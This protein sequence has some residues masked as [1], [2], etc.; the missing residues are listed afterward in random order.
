MEH[1]KVP[2][3][4]KNNKKDES[5]NISLKERV[6]SINK[7]S[8]ESKKVKEGEYPV[9]HCSQE[10]FEAPKMTE[11]SAKKLI[12]FH[13]ADG[14]N[15]YGF[16]RNIRPAA[17]CHYCNVSY[18]IND[19]HAIYNFSEDSIPVSFRSIVSVIQARII[20]MINKELASGTVFIRH[21]SHGNR[22]SFVF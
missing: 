14:N 9:E 22:S 6:D 11:L 17:F 15:G 21:S 20:H 3:A 12:V 10:K 4:Q 5:G 1:E 8:K 19:V 7:S 18:G 13:P 2:R 16:L